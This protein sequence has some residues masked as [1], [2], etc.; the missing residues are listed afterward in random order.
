MK[1][2]NFSESRR[3][4]S[5]GSAVKDEARAGDLGTVRVACDGSLTVPEPH[6]PP[7]ARLADREAE[8][9]GQAISF[10]RQYQ[11]PCRAG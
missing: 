10:L 5:R 2:G 3:P 8:A 4:E 1:A 9:P 11:S 7:H 6:H